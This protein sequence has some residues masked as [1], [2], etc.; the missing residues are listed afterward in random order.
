V[1]VVVL[2][3]CVIAVPYA[4][5]QAP[6]PGGV[7]TLPIDDYQALRARARQ[8]GA[9]PAAQATLTRLD[10]TLAADGELVTGEARLT[11]DVQ[12]TGWVAVPLPAGLAIREAR[13]DGQPLVVD[14]GPPPTV[15]LSRA[16]RAVLHLTLAFVPA[17]A[18]GTATLSLPASTA[19]IT[20]VV[21]DIP[22]TAHRVTATGGVVVAR[23]ERGDRTSWTIHARA[24]APL[25]LDWTRRRDDPRAS[26]PL[27]LAATLDTTAG[28]RDALMQLAVTATLDVR[29]GLAREVAL[30]VPA[31]VTITAVSG[32]GVDDWR[33]EGRV[34]RVLFVEPVAVAAR[35]DIRAEAPAV[36]DTVAIPLLRLPT[37]EREIGTV[38]VD[39]G[40]EAEVVDARVAG[41]EVVDARTTAGARLV[42]APSA[43]TFRFQPAAGAIDR[44]L[45]LTIARYAAEAVPVATIDEARVRAFAAS[46][47][48]VLIE[49]RYLVRNNQRSALA[50]RLPGGAHL[51]QARVGDRAVRPGQADDGRL[52]LPLETARAGDAPATSVVTVVHL[53]Q[54]TPWTIGG[55]ATVALPAIDLPVARSAVLL[56]HPPRTRVTVGE[57]PFRLSDDL[58]TFTTPLG[59][60]APRATYDD[61]RSGAPPEVLALVAEARGVPATA[62]IEPP[63]EALLDFP[64]AGPSVFLRAELTPELVAPVL[65]LSLQKR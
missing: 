21:L 55:R 65:V 8:A 51:W 41:L 46:S 13:L 31:G 57:G 37:A 32:P 64:E 7:V 53:W 25:V 60:A 11:I 4:D 50:V 63:S 18:A 5:A 24:A 16:G 19:A 14:A 39:V 23:S 15:H 52:V 38:A 9:T 33:T 48:R 3:L 26:A 58:D 10:Y 49:A 29:Q 44:R 2:A 6:P 54:D 36:G 45:D 17:E 43:R 42:A 59:Q 61:A 34:L 27:R 47:G 35:L 28:I 40:Q 56:H 30:Q 62:P 12:G 1:F 22:G 20:R